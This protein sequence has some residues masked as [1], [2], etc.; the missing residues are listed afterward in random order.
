MECFPTSEAGPMPE[1]R[2]NLGVLRAP[3]ERIT[4]A[5]ARNLTLSSVSIPMALSGSAG[6]NST[7]ATFTLVRI[8]KLEGTLRRRAEDVIRAPW[9][10][11]LG[12]RERPS[13]LPALRSGFRE[14]WLACQLGGLRKA[15]ER[16]LLKQ[17][18]CRQS[19]EKFFPKF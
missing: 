9:W 7:R 8:L 18:R 3:A 17:P 4:S 19:P 1:R 2:S 16:L 6:E 12:E 15:V 11:V 14:Y 10:A 5:R 13:G